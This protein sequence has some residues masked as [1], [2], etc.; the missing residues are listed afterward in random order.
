VTK[1]QK[2]SSRTRMARPSRR[3]VKHARMALVARA[4]IRK[5]AKERTKVAERKASVPKA[6]SF[7]GRIMDR[8]MPRG[9]KR[10]GGRSA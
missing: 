4:T 1:K 8:V 9:F 5:R 2:R 7:L 3:R 10:T 6:K